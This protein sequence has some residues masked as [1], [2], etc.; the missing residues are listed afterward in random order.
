MHTLKRGGLGMPVRGFHPT[1]PTYLCAWGSIP[2]T[3]MGQRACTIR[4]PD[5]LSFHGGIQVMP[6]LDTAPWVDGAL[7]G[8][9]DILPGPFVVG[10]RVFSL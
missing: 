9:E 6:A 10:V 1:I 7:G 3:E 2:K 8:R 5:S 4:T